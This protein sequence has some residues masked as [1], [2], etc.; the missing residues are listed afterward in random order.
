[1]LLI[2]PH[3]INCIFFFKGLGYNFEFTSN[4]KDI[5]SQ[6]HNN[7]YTHIKLVS[8]CDS[9]C[10]CCPNKTNDSKC[11]YQNNVS[12]LDSHT[13]EYLSIKNNHE[14]SFKEIINTIY[15]N[16]NYNTFIKICSH[17][18]CFKNEVCSK[19]LI[20]EHKRIWLE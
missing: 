5:I 7:P 8:Q 1:M 3:H 15:Q 10:K 4:M 18:E 20:D 16:Y 12:L 6:L 2:R 9:L 19:D 14:Y 17:C 13:L 11:I